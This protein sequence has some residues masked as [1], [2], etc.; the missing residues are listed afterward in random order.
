MCD[1]SPYVMETRISGPQVFTTYD[2]CHLSAMKRLLL[3]MIQT[4][5]DLKEENAS[6]CPHQMCFSY[7]QTKQ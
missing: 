5:D 4:L 3:Q 1:V 2:G 6:S 7:K